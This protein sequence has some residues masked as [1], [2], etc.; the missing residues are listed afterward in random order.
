MK[1][2]LTIKNNE[3]QEAQG[4]EEEDVGPAGK[5][6]AGRKAEEEREER[7]LLQLLG[8]PKEAIEKESKSGMFS[9]Y[10]EI[11]FIY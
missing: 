6:A 10:F 9:L 3:A 7:K 4:D 8:V 1:K 2:S 11:S 5:V